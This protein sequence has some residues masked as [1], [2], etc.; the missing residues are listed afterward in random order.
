MIDNH[1]ALQVANPQGTVWTLGDFNLMGVAPGPASL[2]QPG[3]QGERMAKWF[4]HAL[5]QAGLRALRS[6]AIHVQGGALDIHI[7]AATAAH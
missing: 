7:V 4:V 5:G 1:L 6:P 2:P 3:S